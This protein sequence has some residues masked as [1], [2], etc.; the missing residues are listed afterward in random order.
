MFARRS[1]T[2]AAQSDSEA[3][4]ETTGAALAL[5]EVEVA[6][7]AALVTTTAERLSDEEAAPETEAT[8]PAAPSALALFSAQER[9]LR[10]HG[11]IVVVRDTTS[12][13][14]L[15]PSAARADQQRQIAKLVTAC[16]DAAEFGGLVVVFKPTNTLLRC[17]GDLGWI[18]ADNRESFGTFIDCLYLILYEGAGKDH[19]RYDG[20]LA[21]DEWDVIWAV[22]HLRN[23]MLRHDPDHGAEGSIRKSWRDFAKSAA[24]VGVDQIP[25]TPSEFLE[26]HNRVAAETI[27]FLD[28]LL[29]AI[30]RTGRGSAGAIRD[31]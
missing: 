1:I 25:V 16:N 9:E 23:K 28:K 29:A 27:S 17:I 5:A 2:R 22:K 13:I 30:R 24:E 18:P 10:S 11:P 4:R 3:E 7:S 14:A 20:L 26:A 6:E 31:S 21:K 19:L 12:L 15:S 8:V